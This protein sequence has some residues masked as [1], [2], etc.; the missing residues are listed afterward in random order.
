[1]SEGIMGPPGIPQERYLVAA[2]KA[3]G[4]SQREL[5]SRAGVATATLADFERGA[6]RP[7]RNNFRALCRALGDAGIEFLVDGD[8][9][10][11]VRWPS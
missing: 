5:A 3:L 6:R 11:G 7:M 1:M 9:I 4:W 8:V 2:R 10:H